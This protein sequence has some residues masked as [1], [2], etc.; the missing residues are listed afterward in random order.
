MNP[1]RTRHWRH[2][3]AEAAQAGPPTKEEQEQACQQWVDVEA[4][5]HCDASQ[6]RRDKHDAH[7]RH[8][9]GVCATCLEGG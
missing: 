1:G 3:L 5:N 4:D 9:L 7:H 2:V 8:A 6:K